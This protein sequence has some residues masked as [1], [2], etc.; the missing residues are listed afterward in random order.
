[1][2]AQARGIADSVPVPGPEQVGVIAS[3]ARSRRRARVALATAS[4]ALAVLAAGALALFVLGDR[5]G[6]LDPIAPTPT[7]TPS[8]EPSPSLS[9][10]D[11]PT[12]IATL[13]EGFAPVPQYPL[14]AVPWGDV[15]PGWFLVD[16]RES[17]P[18][19]S[20]DDTGFA[21]A[22][23]EQGG[24]SLVDPA[25]IWYAVRTHG[26]LGRGFPL[27][28]D[29]INVWLARELNVPDYSLLVN[30]G[31][32]R[33]ETGEDAG[34]TRNEIAS[35]WLNW[36]YIATGD[37]TGLAMRYRGDGMAQVGVG[38][39]IGEGNG[40]SALDAGVW[41]RV[42]TDASSTFLP[43]DGGRVVCFVATASDQTDVVVLNTSD[44]SNRSTVSTFRLP[45]E[46]YGFLGWV[47]SDRFIFE[48]VT[49]G[50]E[51]GAWTDAVFE[52]DLRDGSITE[53]DIEAIY[54]AP[55]T[56][57]GF[58][59]RQAQ[60]HIIER[61]ETGGPGVADD[62]AGPGD[63]AIHSADGGEVA[64]VDATC[65]AGPDNAPVRVVRVSGQ[66]LVI[67]CSTTGTMAIYD[68]GNGA[69]VGAWELSEGH[70]INV[71]D[72]PES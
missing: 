38:P 20:G 59:D 40:C 23:Q 32:V 47:D 41:G 15:G 13:I 60:R 26:E 34:D 51:V 2:R 11:E 57:V 16:W 46:R 31:L 58:Y 53:L 56:S 54:Q 61:T 29:G 49:I 19:P 3:A 10:S 30:A 9:P 68:T 5:G 66:R 67:A 33:L 27:T 8:A 28:W 25:G 24:L 39:R 21:P 18:I 22:N 42:P 65:P 36:G 6:D 4:S 48:R 63:V 14:E 1:M 44:P 17:Q 52:F 45:A 55:R 43:G 35:R 69:Q 62:P 71:F 70:A 37:G 12:L 72:Y 64:V 50:F 7:P